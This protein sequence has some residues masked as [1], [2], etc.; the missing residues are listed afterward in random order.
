MFSTELSLSSRVE[1]LSRAILCVKSGG[2]GGAGT[3]TRGAGELL[4]HLEE[5]ME[6]IKIKC[7]LQ[8]YQGK[9]DLKWAVL[10]FEKNNLR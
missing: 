3:N 4:H 10:P 5:K 1:Y 6:V 8:E 9:K 7:R 2:E